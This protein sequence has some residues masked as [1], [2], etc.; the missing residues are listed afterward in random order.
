MNPSREG[1][2]IVAPKN[3]SKQVYS[4][5]PSLAPHPHPATHSVFF[6]FHYLWWVLGYK[7]S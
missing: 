7:E 6:L 3:L 2:T 4:L 1:L 5:P